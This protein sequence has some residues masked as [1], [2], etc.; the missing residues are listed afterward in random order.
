MQHFEAPI[1]CLNKISL[2]SKSQHSSFKL[3]QL[4][5]LILLASYPLSLLAAPPVTSVTTLSA[6]SVGNPVTT[7]AA[8]S[9]LTLTATATSNGTPITSGLVTF[10]DTAVSA[11]CSGSHHLGTAQLTSSGTATLIFF[12]AP[13]A[14]TYIAQFAGTT[15]NASSTST[16]FALAV[17]KSPTIPTQTTLTSTSAQ[18]NYAF[19]ATIT[20]LGGAASPTGTLTLIDTTNNNLSLAQ[21]NPGPGA[22]SITLANSSSPATGHEPASIAVA[23]FNGD[24]KPDLAVPNLGQP[25]IVPSNSGPLTI[26]LNNGDGTFTPAPS[27]ATPSD[28]ASVAAAD[29]NG[30]GIA[31][32]AVDGGVNGSLMIL[33]GKGDGT[34]TQVVASSLNG[35]ITFVAADFNRDGKPDLAAL[36][37]DTASSAVRLY[38]MYGNG[39][40]TFTNSFLPT[41]TAAPT[42]VAVGDFNKDGNPDLAVV[43]SSYPNPTPVSI[44]LNKGD[45]TFTTQPASL[46]A[47]LASSDSPNT[48]LVGDFNG[49]GKDDVVIAT[50]ALSTLTNGDNYI[51]DVFLGNGD[52]SFAPAS[53]IITG[54]ANSFGMAVGDL[55]GDG[56]SDLVT[57]DD[58][59]ISYL[60]GSS[61]GAFTS[62]ATGPGA[63][64]SPDFD[65]LALADF[66]G[67]GVPD[68]AQAD[69]D[70]DAVA[71]YLNTLATTTTVALNNVQ[72]P[73]SG[74][75]NVQAA[76]SGDSAFA[77]SN[78]TSVAVTASLVAT[79]LTL[80]SS[81]SSSVTGAQVVLT[82]TLSPYAAGTITT[83]GESVTFYNGSTSLGTAPLNSGVATLNTTS[84]PLGAN[85]LTAAYAGDTNFAAATSV[86]VPITVANPQPEAV[87]APG[88]LSFPAQAIGA[89][90]A[91]QMVILTN[92]GQLPL[93][94]SATN[95][96]GP[97]AQTNNCGSSLA[98]GANCIISITFTPTTT[99]AATGTL[100]LTDSA[101]NSPQTVSLGGTGE[102]L[103]VTPAA[104]SLTISSPGG[105]ATDTLQISGVN[106]FSGTVG[107]TCAVTYQGTGTANDPPTCSISPAQ[108]Q[109]AVGAT[110]TA[111]L[112]VNTTGA[113]TSSMHD[114]RWGS[115]GI[116]LAA[117][118]FFLLP[119]R[120]W[121]GGLLFAFLG[122]AILGSVIGCSGG[123]GS[124]STATTNLG[125]ATGNYKVVVTAASGSTSMPTTIN[126]TMQ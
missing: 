115:S 125:T 12:P 14:H 114:L 19:T 45:G 44:L 43:L 104:A 91:A 85:T 123:G 32:L 116:A 57:A 36:L 76:Y 94:I 27:P 90:S 15:A 100:T 60:L 4:L 17:T 53:R 119:R 21:A 92:T 95:I 71:I 87:L 65:T 68:L 8:G 7:L 72:V 48:M 89:T 1:F 109:L 47:G 120:R 26:L 79:K 102:G 52:G 122:L 82:A 10:C 66:N 42:A 29:F 2:Q 101:G 13:G 117:L 61:T 113:T 6:T 74:T 75:H 51:V 55:N 88:T 124:Q 63:T 50:E 107:L 78:S 69:S 62:V 35:F 58:N 86:T 20:A 41:L 31:D 112:T 67:D 80:A 96:S 73:G 56:I 33:L 106:G 46:A 81:T 98:V 105:T 111:T 110:L 28:P 37:Y 84:I 18:P 16:A 22:A 93:T 83:N 103:A 38:V 64:T 39:D 121:S 70:L 40:G 54:L 24:G 11:F 5:L 97:F 126:L 99:G 118:S 25:G 9:L 34:F 77:A 49:D 3:L 23:D 59:K 108:A 30:D